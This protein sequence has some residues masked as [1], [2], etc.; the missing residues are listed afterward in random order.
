MRSLWPLTALALASVSAVACT[1]GPT[2]SGP[3]APG[4]ALSLAGAPAAS[5]PLVIRFEG[6]YAIMVSFDLA[7]GM[8]AVY[9][10]RDGFVGCGESFTVFR[11]AQYQDV[12]NPLIQ[13]L[14][15][16]LFRADAFVTVYPWEGQDI[17][18]DPC[19]FLLD[20]PK[21]ATGTARLLRTDNNLFGAVSGRANAFGYTAEGILDLTGGGKA[22]Y[23]A[24]S[25]AVAT[26]EGGFKV[27]EEINLVLLQ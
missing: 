26:P 6:G 18:T 9:I 14:V 11:P 19:G 3:A 16:E 24:I 5:G 23:N 13:D 27:T 17:E 10:A 1:D 20:T 2:A 7:D 15:N 12:S 22:H 21:I 4:T 8:L 25:R